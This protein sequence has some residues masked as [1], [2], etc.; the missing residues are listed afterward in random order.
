LISIQP[1]KRLLRR[2][3]KYSFIGYARKGLN[4]HS[5]TT[6]SPT[7]LSPPTLLSLRPLS[8]TL[9]WTLGCANI[10]AA[11]LVTLGG[12]WDLSYH[13]TFVVDTFLSPPHLLIYG[14]LLATL[15]I[16]LSA[17][18]YLLIDALRNRQGI[19]TLSLRPL[20][21]LPLLANL[22]FLAGGPLDA[23]WHA[24]FGRDVLSAWSPPHVFLALS[25]SMMAV[26]G[27][28]LIHWLLAERP[29]GGLVAPGAHRHRSLLWCLETLG[30]GCAT[31]TLYG[32]V[33][34][35]EVGTSPFPWVIEH[36]WL[37]LPVSV[38]IATFLFSLSETLLVG[39]PRWLLPAGIVVT[40]LLQKAPTTLV[41]TLLD[42][43]DGFAFKTATVL[44]VLVFTLL[45]WL[46]ERWPRWLRW[47][48]FGASY[49]GVALLA[50]PLGFLATLS[51]FD[52]L[53][54]AITLPFLAVVAGT[55]GFKLGQLI[56]RLSSER[57]I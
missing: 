14:G 13:E 56:D 4:M 27:A 57:P 7:R 43:K 9:V 53:V 45:A 34:E 39:A 2:Y 23:A 31:V 37:A 29:S 42:Y 24:A 46:G 54:P 32:L 35:W 33:G 41:H 20:V 49:L 3:N 16:G 6:P 10:A 51:W 30:L 48:C 15:L 1:Q 5:A 26:G 17:S 36:R 25:L 38:I 21:T 40:A 19:E 11:L 8:R 44:A 50:G 28:A 18:M 52:I 55:I 22:C 12:S 47:A